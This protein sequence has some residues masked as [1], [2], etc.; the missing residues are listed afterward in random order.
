MAV[1]FFPEFHPLHTRPPSGLIRELSSAS[2]D[3][4]LAR[5]SRSWDL[6]AI[7]KRIGAF[8]PAQSPA[9]ARKKS[10]HALR[11]GSRLKPGHA[12]RIQAAFP[13]SHVQFWWSHPLAC[14]LCDRKLGLDGAMA[15]LRSLPAGRVR[16]EI[17][18]LPYIT[19]TATAEKLYPWSSDLITRLQGH[20]SVS[21][22]CALVC[23]YRVEQLLGNV[24]HG[25]VA[26]QAIWAMLPLVIRRSRNLRVCMHTLVLAIDYFLR[27]QPFATERVLDAALEGAVGRADSFALSES[28]WR[29]DRS[30]PGS[31]K[32]LR[33]QNARS[34]ESYAIDADWCW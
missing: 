6:G 16:S 32:E 2:V 24:D 26:M 20:G 8:K 21:A 31:I 18:E 4:E 27:L 1:Q 25:F 33:R 9:D 15:L 11:A 30:I 14:I 3:A 29:S 34:F 28:I 22:F 17:W 10:F 23:R 7:E 5:L 13:T 12:E 19:R